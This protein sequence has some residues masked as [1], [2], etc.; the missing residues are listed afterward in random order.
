MAWNVDRVLP[1]QQLWWRPYPSMTLV[2]EAMEIE[3]MIHLR[4]VADLPYPN[5]PPADGSAW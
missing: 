2:E 3:R 4:L 1:G 5:F